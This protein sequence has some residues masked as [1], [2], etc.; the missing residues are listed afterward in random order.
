MPKRHPHPTASALAGQLF[1][2]I[3]NRDA[4]RDGYAYVLDN[5]ESGKNSVKQ[6]VLEMMLSDEFID[7]YLKG[8]TLSAVKTVN[9]VLLG[10]QLDGQSLEQETKKYIRTGLKSYIEE[11]V[12]SPAYRNAAG[13][14]GVPLYGH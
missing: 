4:D 13:E 14:D 2:K 8:T 12:N 3:L 11:L 7:G 1:G 5:L 10:R 6:H 9:K